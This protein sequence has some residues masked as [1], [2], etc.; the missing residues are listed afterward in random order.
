MSIKLSVR[1][2][3]RRLHIT[4]REQI[5]EQRAH[6]RAQRSCYKKFTN[7]C[8]DVFGAVRS[9]STQIFNFFVIA[10]A[11]PLARTVTTTVRNFKLIPTRSFNGIKEIVEPM[12][13]DFSN[14]VN[15]TFLG[16]VFPQTF[17]DTY[18]VPNS[19]CPLENLL[20]QANKFLVSPYT[21]SSF[22]AEHLQGLFLSHVILAPICEE[23]HYRDF[24]QE[25]ICN[26]Y[27][28]KLL[29]IY[30]PGKE[31]IVDDKI[32]KV[33][34]VFLSASLFSLAHKA[35]NFDQVSQSYQLVNTFV[36]GLLWGLN[37]EINPGFK[38]TLLCISSH[39]LHNFIALYIHPQF[40]NCGIYASD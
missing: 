4:H 37:K 8:S 18:S 15:A 32:V 5:L 30:M 14:R 23:L 26:T 33:F 34:R 38:G 10:G 20:E 19:L 9:K 36:L 1:D 35:N 24:I 7:A 6:A 12:A 21:V 16:P 28:R 40:N 2:R 3:A 29:Q 31:G 25:S 39:M 13:S 17:I 22:R 27:P 11:F